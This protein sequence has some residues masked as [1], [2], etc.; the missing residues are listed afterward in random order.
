MNASRRSSPLKF[1]ALAVAALVS[2]CQDAPRTAPGV[3]GPDFSISEARFG[4]QRNPDIFFAPPLAA[5]PASGDTGFDVGAANGA[6]IPY[7]R[8]CETNGAGSVSGCLV[9]VTAAV[10]GSASGLAMAFNGSAELYQV[11]W[12]T[13]RL[14]VAK[15]YRIEIWGVGFETSAERNQLLA[16]TFPDTDPLLPGRPRWL[17]GWRD[18]ANAPSVSACH[19]E[20]DFCLIKYGQNLPVK[21]RIEDYV[22]C[23]VARNCA[24]QFVSSGVDANLEATLEDEI[25]ASVQLL[26]P[27]Q[28]G[29]DFPLGFE[30]CS[31]AEKAAVQAYSAIPTFGPCVKTLAVST[32]IRLGEP[33]LLS[34][35]TQFDEQAILD[36]LAVPAVQ[37]DLVGV[38]H[39]STGGDPTG[40]IL[41]MEAWPHAAPACQESTS[42]GFA[43]IDEP[44]GF[45]QF[46]Q[47]TGRRFLSLFAS[48]PVVALDI[49]GGGEG[50]KL[51]SYYMLG[52][53]TK[54]EY[55]TPTD[56]LQRGIAGG[57]HALRAKATDLYGNPVWGA[58]VDWGVISSPGGAAVAT[59]PVL[60][61]PNGIAQTT[62][63]LSPT[64]G[65]NVFRAS[66]RGIADARE[67]GCTLIGGS[68]GAASCNGPR[69]GFD[70]FQPHTS[71]A[72]GG[73]QVIPEGT[74]L[75]F[76]VYGCAQGRGTATTDGVLAAGEWDCANSTSFPAKLSGGSTVQGTLRWMNDADRLYIAVRVPGSARE[77]A[78]RIEWDSDG[79]GPTATPSGGAYP[80]PREAGDDVWEFIPGS[81]AMDKFIDAA[82]SGSGQSSCGTNDVGFGGG[83]QTLAGFNNTA[84]GFT[85][86]EISHPL[87]TADLC[88]NADPRKGCGSL[89][90]RP[91][92]LRASAGNA[93]GFFLALRLGSG[94]QGNT[95]WP[96]FLQYMKV[97]IE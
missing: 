64:E 90:G 42:G 29:T 77:N 52:L 20:E 26:I 35:C 57:Q 31:A 97:V 10:T 93:R 91:I 30:P 45:A 51:W 55:E 60:T 53:P 62:V 86:Y 9:D 7:V 33:A 27:G 95:Q 69:S 28:P 80:T 44:R 19:G 61:G 16:V 18:I 54:F 14:D 88:T 65:N 43:S 73:I 67:S 74:R 56:S 85:T 59:T 38:H 6:L 13:D 58:R 36:Q 75:P 63:T 24:V 5:T 15:S 70:P 3:L 82:C 46:A 84:G 94:A 72:L 8:V 37:H 89:L 1:F 21:V 87:T 12:K 92:D 32:P 50:W 17:F 83:M 11:N 41:N 23:P 39:F 81:G 96:G 34:Y 78:L 22:L 49:G 66:G 25:A 2:A 40:P 76:T 68:P 4:G 48:E 47:A 79:D 71:P